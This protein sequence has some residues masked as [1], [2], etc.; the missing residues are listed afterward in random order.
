MGR[1][2][3]GVQETNQSTI[4]EYVNQFW[5]Q[6][7]ACLLRVNIAAC[8]SEDKVSGSGKHHLQLENNS[9]GLFTVNQYCDKSILI[10]TILMEEQA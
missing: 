8:Q 3:S 5:L 4:S 10:N 2:L 7:D 1:G 9:I 6:Y